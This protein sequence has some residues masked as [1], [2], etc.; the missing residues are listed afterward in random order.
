MWNE[1]W[2]KRPDLPHGHDG[3]QA[4][5]ATPQETSGGKT[6]DFTAVRGYR[7]V[8]PGPCCSKGG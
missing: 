1:S 4:F 2:F 7:R 3:W 5:D 8:G 6:V